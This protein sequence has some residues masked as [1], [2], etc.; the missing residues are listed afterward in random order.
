MPK[1]VYNP[2][3]SEELQLLPSAGESSYKV[4][5]KTNILASTPTAGNAAFASDTNE[6]MVAD[7][8]HW[9]ISHLPMGLVET[10]PSMGA[11]SYQNDWGY[12]KKDL[13]NKYLRSVTLKPFD[14]ALQTG[15]NGSLSFNLTTNMFQGFS[16]GVWK[17]F[18]LLTQVEIN[19]ITLWSELALGTVYDYY[20]NNR[21]HMEQLDIG[22]FATEHL[23]TGGAIL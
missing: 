19:D 21:L 7:G 20:G 11:F 22:A 10:A 13:V 9:V 12:G 3:H 6:F 2:V 17:N 1:I 4:D 5:T 16:G 15:E 23:I 18:R 14:T 8:T